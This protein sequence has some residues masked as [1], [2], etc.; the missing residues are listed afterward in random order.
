MHSYKVA[1]I[2]ICLDGV[3]TCQSDAVLD[4]NCGV[5]N[6]SDALIMKS[7]ALQTNVVINNT[8]A[9]LNQSDVFNFKSDSISDGIS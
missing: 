8:D 3:I 6:C 4:R 2:T 1:F 5:I 9:V 7:D